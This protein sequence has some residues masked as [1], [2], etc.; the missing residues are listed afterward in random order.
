MECPEGVA[1]SVFP[2]EGTNENFESYSIEWSVEGD[3]SHSVDPFWSVLD[4]ED[5]LELISF[6]I[7]DSAV[8]E[9]QP[10]SIII[11]VMLEGIP[12]SSERTYD[13]D[14]STEVCNECTGW[15]GCKDD[16]YTISHLEIYL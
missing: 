5:N 1:V 4:D 8:V 2:Q 13:L 16:M 10:A 9:T 12:V 6:Y 15:I 11:V 7:N 3:E 14:W